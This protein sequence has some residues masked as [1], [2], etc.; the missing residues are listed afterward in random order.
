MNRVLPGSL[1]R[2]ERRDFVKVAAL[3]V[4]AAVLPGWMS[5]AAATGPRTGIIDC[6]ISL[7][8]W[9]TRRMRGDETSTLVR[10]L[11]EC[12]VGEA[13]AGSLEGMLCKDLGSANER[14]ARE[15]R[16]HGK[17]IL[18]PF[19]TINPGAPGWEDDLERCVRMHKMRGIRVYPN[20][21]QYKLDD[22]RFLSLLRCSADHNLIVQ[23]P[24]HMED[25]RMMHPLLQV[26]AVDVMPLQNA[27]K[28]VPGCRI[29]LLNALKTYSAAKLKPLVSAGTVAVEISMLEGL[30]AVRQLLALLSNGKVLFGT[31]APLFYLESAFLKLKESALSAAEERALCRDNALQFSQPG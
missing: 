17:G 26:P 21:H 13:W 19:G 16:E 6:N 3:A 22:T 27:L 8:R 24:V 28:R 20:Y 12:G 1:L 2:I 29:V 18:V 31:N 9:P 15:C 11:E 4:G 10:M 23:I 30:G 7:F 25:E 5:D 14:L